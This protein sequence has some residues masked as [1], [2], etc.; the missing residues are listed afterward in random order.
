MSN[1]QDEHED[2]LDAVKDIWKAVQRDDYEAA[3]TI[4]RQHGKDYPELNITDPQ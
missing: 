3:M 4:L 2:A 1:S